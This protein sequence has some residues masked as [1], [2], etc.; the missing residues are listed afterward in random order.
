MA[1]LAVLNSPLSSKTQLHLSVDAVA[2]EDTGD[3]QGE[4]SKS[5]D[6]PVGG[7]T[8]T[9]QDE[10]FNLVKNIIGAGVLSLP[11]GVAAYGNAPSAVIPA[12]ALITVFGILSGYC[13][14]LVG[15]IC[16][17]TNSFSFKEA[18]GKTVGEKSS[19]IPTLAC[20]YLP[21]SSALTYSM[22]LADT[23]KMIADSAGYSITRTNS[24][25]G[26]TSF[27]ILPICLLKNLASLAPFSLLGI[28]GMV[29]TTLAMTIRYFGDAYKMPAGRFV[30]NLAKE[31]KPAF[32]NVGAAG[33]LSP[34][35]FIIICILSTGYVVH[36]NAPK[37]YNELKDNTIARYNKV[38]SMSFGIS[39]ALSAAIAA[40]GFLTFG[41]NSSGLIL[42]NY[43]SKDFLA[44][45]TRI[46]VAVS[47]I[48]TYP[49]VF[50]GLRD[51]ILDLFN[52]PLE[53]RT[54]FRLDKLTV[55]LLSLITY[56]AIKVKDLTFVISFGGA[57][58]GNALIYVFP[59]LMFRG[60]VKKMDKPSDRLKMEVKATL[61]TAFLGVVMGAIGSVMAIKSLMA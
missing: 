39:I 51:G 37:F 12:V 50:S 9:I 26:I 27:I 61:G 46:A 34:N 29:Y 52:C 59:A 22:I 48:F 3:S 42:N 15:R 13:F 4:K 36:F 5:K 17:F 60:A 43:A 2:E 54:N 1:P 8:A 14:S 25:F 49:L 20:I 35:A 16:S 41:K 55:G 18:W 32:G 47:L 53:A 57:T 11:A 6:S 10:V 7:G 56:L 23:G 45:M 40:M 19:W 28:L 33:V 58:T 44:G 31:Y 21:L 30:V 38:V 24:L